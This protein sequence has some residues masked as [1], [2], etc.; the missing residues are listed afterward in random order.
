MSLGAFIVWRRTGQH[1]QPIPHRHFSVRQPPIGRREASC[2]L[3]SK[4]FGQPFQGGNAVLIGQERNHV[5][6]PVLHS[7]HS[8]RRTC[9]VGTNGLRPRRTRDRARNTEATERRLRSPREQ[10]SARKCPATALGIPAFRAQER[11]V[12]LCEPNSVLARLCT[13]ARRPSRN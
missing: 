6:H 8:Q 11:Q 7:P 2:L 10:G 13:S 1:D 5:W 9:F 4:R 3:E 12:A